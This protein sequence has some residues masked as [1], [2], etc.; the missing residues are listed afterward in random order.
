MGRADRRDRVQ[1]RA[2]VA[3]DAPRGGAG[4]RRRRLGAAA[5]RGRAESGDGVLRPD[6]RPRAPVVRVPRLVDG[7]AGGGG[8]PGLRRLSVRLENGARGPGRRVVR[9]DAAA[10]SAHARLLHGRAPV[11]ASKGR[12]GPL[13]LRGLQKTKSRQGAQGEA[14]V[15]DPPRR[16]G[17]PG[18]QRGLRQKTAGGRDRR[19]RRVRRRGGENRKGAEAQAAAREAGGRDGLEP[20]RRRPLRRHV[21]GRAVRSR[22]DVERMGAAASFHQAQG[23]R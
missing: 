10:A 23:G 3:H 1:R 20:A 2:V 19:G 16:R 9:R 15:A 11:Q 7:G 22:H 14:R 5:L 4:G 13:R 8:P 12:G 18:G 6:A 21:H 17:A